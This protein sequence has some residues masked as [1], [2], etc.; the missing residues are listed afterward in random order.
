VVA[1]DGSTRSTIRKNAYM[2]HQSEGEEHWR[3]Q[4]E[5][6]FY[7]H[8]GKYQYGLRPINYGWLIYKKGWQEPYITGRLKFHTCELFAYLA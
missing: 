5:E 7:Y 4:R 3:D 8:L 2:L 1:S 6:T